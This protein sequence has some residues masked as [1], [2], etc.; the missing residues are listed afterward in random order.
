MVTEDATGVTSG[1]WQLCKTQVIFISF[2][3]WC[4][5]LHKSLKPTSRCRPTRTIC[6]KIL[7]FIPFVL[8]N[9]LIGRYFVWYYYLCGI[10][11]ICVGE[12]K[13]KNLKQTQ[14]KFYKAMGR[15]LLFYGSEVWV[16]KKPHPSF[17]VEIFEVSERIHT[18]DRFRN[19]GIRESFDVFGVHRGIQ[20]TRNSWR[21]IDHYRLDGNGF[22]KGAFA[23][24]P[25][26]REKY[27]AT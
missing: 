7:L 20:E 18:V 19:D 13:E 1:I 22:Q 21:D 26:G 25:K 27:W 11:I 9:K 15:P 12:L 3:I 24:F 2:E 10:I 14:L 4:L 17:G 16:W 8:W 23:C 6:C 5:H